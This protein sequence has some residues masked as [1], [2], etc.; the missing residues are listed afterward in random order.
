MAK[1]MATLAEKMPKESHT[2]LLQ[3][4]RS[5]NWCDP[6]LPSDTK[7]SHKEFPPNY[8]RNF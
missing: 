3:S 6:E 5:E 2:S 8:F 1:D 4:G 7:L